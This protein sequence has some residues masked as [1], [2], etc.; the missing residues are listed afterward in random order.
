MGKFEFGGANKKGVYFD[1][2]NRR[3]LLNIRS[4]Y[5]EAAG[6]LADKGK[7]DE[8]IRLLEKADA[9]I[10]A[11][12]MAYGMVSRYSL[13][14]Q[15][16]LLFLEACYKAGKADLAERVRKDLRK[17][18]EDQQKY[19]AYI[20]AEKPEFA[21]NLEAESVFNDVALTVLSAI[22]QRYAPQTQPAVTPAET[23]PTIENP[24]K[25]KDSSTKNKPDSH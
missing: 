14:N 17:D 12:S 18:I 5:A 3:H 10:P 22:E 16:G 11:S 24:I 21:G 4:A 7:K 9:G 1:E 13:H 8:A 20:K 6:N 2:E 23:T 15:T 19:Y 25:S